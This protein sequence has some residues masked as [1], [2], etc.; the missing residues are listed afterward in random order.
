MVILTVLKRF[1]MKQL[2]RPGFINVSENDAS[3]S[4]HNFA[5]PWN[6]N[7]GYVK[8]YKPMV[9][10]DFEAQFHRFKKKF[11]SGCVWPG[12]W[13]LPFIHL[14]VSWMRACG[15]AIASCPRIH[16]ASL[17]WDDQRST[18]TDAQITNSGWPLCPVWRLVVSYLQVCCFPVRHHRLPISGTE[19]S[20]ED[21][22]TKFI[23]NSFNFLTIFHLDSNEIIWWKPDIHLSTATS[24]VV[25]NV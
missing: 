1:E 19:H 23:P 20:V 17:Y 10:C 21:Q 11:G 18:M 24:N 6:L 13:Y 7:Q 4:L 3:Y 15:E 5:Y 14:L 16:R 2:R 25:T 9:H 8:E 12:N 22:D